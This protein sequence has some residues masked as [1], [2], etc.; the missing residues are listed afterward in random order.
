MKQIKE[1]ITR[2]SSENS[3]TFGENDIGAPKVSS[4]RIFITE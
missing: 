2:I 1:L 3:I 4:L